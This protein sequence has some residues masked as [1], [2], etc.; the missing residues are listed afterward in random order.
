[1]AEQ[2]TLFF[3]PLIKYYLIVFSQQTDVYCAFI[4]AKAN[5]KTR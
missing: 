2:V 4:L 5:I 3:K 1:M